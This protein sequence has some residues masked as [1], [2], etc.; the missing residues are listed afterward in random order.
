MKNSRVKDVGTC[1]KTKRI[2][3]VQRARLGLVGASFSSVKNLLTSPWA[4]KCILES[5]HKLRTD[6]RK[7]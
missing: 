6:E 5:Q 4:R 1:D 2:V 3:E 7:G